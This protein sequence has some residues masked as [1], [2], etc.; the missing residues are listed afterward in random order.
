MASM[1]TPSKFA[2]YAT[3][4]SVATEAFG[5]PIDEACAPTRTVS[6]C[7]AHEH[8]PERPHDRWPSQP[9]SVVLLTSTST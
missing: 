8:P 2:L 5:L 9:S 7:P 1:K 4:A 6:Q 3:L